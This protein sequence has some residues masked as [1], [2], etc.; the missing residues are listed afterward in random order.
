VNTVEKI[1]NV[2]QTQFF[3]KKKSLTTEKKQERDGENAFVAGD[4]P[5]EWRCGG[6]KK[7]KRRKKK[8]KQQ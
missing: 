5:S 8:R 2:P 3:L 6:L 7:M 4:F 1:A